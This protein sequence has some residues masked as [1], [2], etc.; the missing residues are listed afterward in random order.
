MAGE[1]GARGWVGDTAVFWAER[2]WCWGGQRGRKRCEGVEAQPIHPADGETEAL[3][4][5]AHR[6]VALTEQKLVWAAGGSP[7]CRLLPSL[8]C[9][10]PPHHLL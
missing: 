2:R 7:C 3:G 4:L 9:A 10:Q 5:S 6:S 1:R 8:P